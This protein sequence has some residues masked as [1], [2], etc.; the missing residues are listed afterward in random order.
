MSAQ[1]PATSASSVSGA[2]APPRILS[3]KFATPSISASHLPRLHLLE[4]MEQSSARLIL[5]RAAAGF[6]KTTLL[7][8]YR[9]RCL[10][11]ERQVLWLNLDAADNDLQRF[12]AHLGNGLR[13]LD[14]TPTGEPQGLSQQM[15]TLLEELSDR[16]R[17][18]ALLLDEF[19][20]IHNPAVLNFVQQLIDTL[21]PCGVL[22]LASRSTP[23]IGLGRI[24]ARGQ[25]LEFNPGAL[26]FSLEEA[27][28]FIRD[29]RE[30]PLRDAE[31]ATLYRCT[32]GWI[33]AIYLASLSLQGRNDH[34]A[35]V[36]SFSGS[37]LELAEYLTEDILAR[38]SEACRQF[39]LL[40]SVLD[41]LSVPLCN[42]V[43]GGQD[44][45]EMLAYL[46]RAN[47]FLFPLDSE[48]QW[49]RYH[50]LFASYLRDALQRY[51]PGHAAR[52]HQLAAQWYLA[53]QR[54]VPAIDHL[55]QAGARDEAALHLTRHV[56]EFM[57][58]GRSRLLLR[59]LDQI[60]P[61]TLQRYPNL[62][63]GYSWTL[64]LH[65]RY[66]DALASIALIRGATED[67]EQPL[68]LEAE[69]I[70]CLLFALTD[71]VEAC[72]EAGL[73]HIQRIPDDEQFQ[74]GVIA[75]CLGYSLV[76]TGRYEEARRLLSRAILRCSQS[77]TQS[78]GSVA[79]CLEGALDMI[80]GRLGNAVARLQ[81]AFPTQ[82]AGG[83]EK[84]LAGRPSLE[85]TLS[86][87]LYE[88]D[89]LDEVEQLLGEVLPH[90]KESSP[91][92]SLISCHVLL[93]R[94]ALLKGDR[95][96][97]LR[98]LAD[99]EQIGQQ[100]GS[101]RVICSAWLERAR[102]ATLENRLE[103]ARQALRYA[104]LHGD[105]ERPGIL[106]HGND[107]DTPS[108][109]RFRLRIA[110]GDCEDTERE[111]RDAM[112]EA[113]ARQ[114]HRRELKL[115]LLHALA[116]NA[117]ERTEEAFEAL[118]EALR[119]A[120]H[121]GFMRTFLDEGPRLGSLLQRWAVPHQ[122]QSRALGIE[123][124]FLTALLQRFVGHGETPSNGQAPGAAGEGLTTREIQ[125]IRL[126][127]AGHRNKVIA[128]KMFL[129]EFTVKSHLRNINAKLGAQGRTEAVAIARARGLLD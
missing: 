22:V 98:L 5:I 39:L 45:Q 73:A 115:R 25:L 94:V 36:S 97:W 34:A 32:E 8:Q 110:Q 61:Q 92:D 72:C 54:P 24:R 124:R 116:L 55:L 108:I 118:S 1:F 12:V 102:A 2:T 75:N 101:A 100:S 4:Q 31:I 95:D 68:A 129:S 76:S 85:I 51:Y 65:R 52:L 117:L 83:A 86:I 40:T 84:I 120:S 17:P 104:E 53:E 71:Q 114:H 26:R 77:R 49:F 10:A 74:Y 18:F 20:A 125:V 41:Q 128:E 14:A 13:Q 43:T 15:Q 80:Q 33:T 126:L 105:W 99:L 67:G 89:A 11:Q 93:A 90:A 23:D 44:G 107:V 91:P 42:A 111:L 9:E 78:M 62:C 35:F 30:L 46:E 6:G 81:A 3:S 106:L 37:N 27:T 47:L 16:T 63:L 19:E 113:N 58:V 50:S 28:R 127:A 48:H 7:Q 103:S 69:T 121:E 70:R 87:A 60:P 56:G 112:A 57:D 88:T 66:T 109:A 96:A 82:T 123:P 79:S 64:A 29:K 21:P 38:Q 119:F 122:A 59:W